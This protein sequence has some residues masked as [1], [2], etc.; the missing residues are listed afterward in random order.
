MESTSM[1]Y[2]LEYIWLGGS[3]EFR[4]KV[5]IMDELPDFPPVWNYDGS[6]T[7]QATTETSQCTLIPV[8]TYTD[9]KNPTYIYVLCDTPER[10]QMTSIQDTLDMWVGFEQE[11]FI[12]DLVMDRSIGSYGNMPPQGPYYCG[13]EA[14][15]GYDYCR[16]HTVADLL[17]LTE[18]IARRCCDIG[19]ELTGYNLEVAPG[20]TEIQVMSRSALKACDD[21]MM[22]RF[23]AHRVLI[24]ERCKPVWDPKPLGPEW[25]GTGLHTN[26][27]TGATRCEGGIRAI[28]EY[29]DLLSQKHAEHLTVYGSGNETRLTGRH[30][31]SSMNIFT[32]SVG[33]RHT[34]VRIPS[35]VSLAGCGYF[36]DRRPAG[37]AN[38]YLIA[39]RILRTLTRS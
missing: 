4:S 21:L 16:K 36:E 17:R 31:T 12:W 37:N 5:R 14:I 24:A 38:P 15:A 35:E 33:G 3:N 8:R 1:T 23:M 30:E 9:R 7:G 18:L 27:S 11:F 19:C 29:M 32:W 13:V 22:M 28:H 6:S 34:S 2:S 25:N 26:I 39:E 10:R 20:Q